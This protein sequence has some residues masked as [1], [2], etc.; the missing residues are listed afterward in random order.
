MEI[1]KP[2]FEKYRKKPIVIEA[3]RY[4]LTYPTQIETLEGVMTV[5]PGDWVIKGVNGELYPCKDDIFK[6]TYDKVDK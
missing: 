1:W 2:Q 4:D 3:Y 5:S 6:K